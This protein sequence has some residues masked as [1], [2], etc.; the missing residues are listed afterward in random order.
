MCI[1]LFCVLQELFAPGFNLNKMSL[2]ISFFS[3]GIRSFAK[4]THGGS[5]R[6]TC[7]TVTG[8]LPDYHAGKQTERAYLERSEVCSKD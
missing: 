8:N 4:M 2:V 3:A 1:Y 5:A 6:G 7:D